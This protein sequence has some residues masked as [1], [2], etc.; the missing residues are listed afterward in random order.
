MLVCG[1][2]VLSETSYAQQ[3]P[4]FSQ[5]QFTKLYYNPAVAGAHD[6]ICGTLLYRN[7]WTGFGGEPKTAMLTAEMPLEVL[8]GGVGL[9]LHA[10]DKLGA[11]NSLNIRANYSYQLDLGGGRLGI[12]AGIGYVQESLNGGKLIYNDAGDQSIPTGNV[13]GGTYDLAF[14]LYYHTEQ[15]YVGLSSTH[16]TQSSLKYADISTQLA[17]HYFLQAGYSYDLTSNL[18]IRP[19]VFI[20]TDAVETQVD[21]NANLFINNKYWA[22]AAYRL[23]DAIVIMAGIELM[24]NLRFGYSYDLTTSGI[25]TYSSGSHEIVLNYCFSPT[26]VVKRQ[27]HRNVRFL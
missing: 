9:S 21:F 2:F 10:L 25:K 27:F 3:D 16:L 17:R 7:Q 8:R 19:A 26:K 6:A 15:L 1:L 14:G 12:G 4:Q 24:P 22:G 18:A 13:S 11:G 5:H 20:K 23:Q